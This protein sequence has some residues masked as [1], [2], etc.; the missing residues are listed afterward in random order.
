[1]SFR[2]QF[3]M[4]AAI[5][6]CADASR[7]FRLTD[8]GLTTDLILLAISWLVMAVGGAASAVFRFSKF[9]RQFP[10]EEDHAD[11]QVRK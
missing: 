2:Q 8:R 7:G 6:I 9:L 10:R 3:I 4:C 5:V 1:M 11:E